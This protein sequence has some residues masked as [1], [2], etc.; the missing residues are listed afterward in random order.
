MLDAQAVGNDVVDLTD[1]RIVE[2][3]RR[4]RF[5]SRVCAAQERASITTSADLW[6]LFAAKEAAYKALIKLGHSPGFSHREIL[7]APDL[8]AVSWRGCDLELSVETSK[9]HVHALAWRGRT[10]RPVAIV[11]RRSTRHLRAGVETEGAA[12]RKLLCAL[13]GAAT[14]HAAGELEVVRD[15]VA[16]AWDGFGPPR[17]EC[18]GI[19]VGADVSLSH[20]GPFVA[21]AAMIAACSP[22]GL[23]SP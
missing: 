22:R 6:A 5:V 2:H 7:V 8:R 16:G 3:H 4:E 20:D 18:R 1:P 11:S 15:P 17:V 19:V 14:G 10:C 13:V 12:A 23:Q 9:H 21:A